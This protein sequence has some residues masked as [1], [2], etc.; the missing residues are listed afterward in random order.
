M[1]KPD[2]R[3]FVAGAAGLAVPAILIALAIPRLIEGIGTEQALPATTAAVFER[4]LPTSNYR[5]AAGVLSSTLADNGDGLIRRAEMLALAAKGNDAELAEAR[6]VVVD[7]LVKAPMNPRGW[8]LLC[9]IDSHIAPAQAPRCMDTGFFVA[10]FDWFVAPRRALLAAYLWPRLDADVQSAAARRVRLMWESDSWTDHRARQSL[11]D[12][13]RAPNGAALL[14]AGFRTDPDELRVVN[15]WL[16]Q[17]Q[18]YGP[19]Q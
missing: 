17:K 1:R 5:V 4:T 8:T 3:I 19:G 13:Y 7:G 14:T 12:V 10:P 15:R 16:M 2:W 11:F 9:E 6:A 18:M